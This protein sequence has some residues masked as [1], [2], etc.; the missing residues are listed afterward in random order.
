M[1]AAMSAA[2]FLILITTIGKHFV[3]SSRCD[4]DLSTESHSIMM[5]GDV[6]LGGIMQLLLERENYDDF[7]TA[8]L[9]YF[10]HIAA[11]VFAVEEINKHPDLLPNITLGFHIYDTCILE[12]QAIKSVLTILTGQ[13]KIIPNYSCNVKNTVAAFI[14]HHISSSTFATAVLTGIYRYPQITYGYI[15]PVFNNRIY[16][17]SLFQMVPNEQIQSK[18]IALLLQHFGW[19]WVGIVTSDN[20]SNLR[21]S[22]ELQDAIVRRGGCVEFIMTIKYLVT[23]GPDFRKAM[24]V[25][26]KS[27]CTVIILNTSA[28]ALLS[29]LLSMAKKLQTRKIVIL[30]P[31]QTTFP[32][33]NDNQYIHLFNGSLS[34][35]AHRGNIPGL[36]EFLLSGDISK[37]TDST[38]LKDVWLYAFLCSFPNNTYCDE[39]PIFSNLD[40]AVYDVDNFRMTHN[41][42]AAVHA[43]AHALHNM[44]AHS[45]H[46]DL[47]IKQLRQD[48]QPWVITDYLRKVNFLT[49]GGEEIYFSEEEKDFVKFDIINY[50]VLLNKT[51]KKNHVG[52]LISTSQQGLQISINDSTIQ[53]SSAFTQ[54]PHSVCSESCPPGFRKA[55]KKGRPKCCFDCVPCSE[56]EISNGTVLWIF[57]MYIKTPIVKANNQNLSYIL[58]VSLMLCFLCSLL[59]IGRPM[60]ITC[61]IRQAAF[62]IIFTIAVSSVL[63]KTMTV[64]IAFNA[65]KPNSKLRKWVGTR[66]PGCLILIC[67]LGEVLICIV[68][69]IYS[70]PFP[71]YDTHSEQDKMILQCNEGSATIFYVMVSYIGFLAFFCFVVAF[72][73]RKLPDTFNE[74]Q[75][76]TFS[77]LVF[78][79]VWVSFIPT[80]VSTKGKY[81]VAVEVFAILTSGAGLLCCIFIPKCH[82]I[83]IRPEFNT[84][85]CLS[86]KKATF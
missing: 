26:E 80:Y 34:V 37:Y 48:W 6:I 81:M 11:F 36:R 25:I 54:T 27:S 4:L 67:S 21:K 19:S 41:V 18:A 30:P 82:T 52:H 73:V 69:W 76:I 66:I 50:V 45:N 3:S 62:G 59:F 70:P 12:S 33:F 13:R 78:C 61:L 72:L 68:W 53:W 55:P 47:D 65:M 56:G 84:R 43:V 49:P 42:Y 64:V 38:I 58:L 14:G 60:K 63:A 24:D 85:E 35:M 9:H 75:Y 2:I 23:E 57:I 40:P 10:R 17:S 46:K 22:L 16:F 5:D 77:M 51:I 79:S 39:K 7:D 44:Y 15:D 83:L 8:S 29:I 31:A 20:E 32:V 1:H 71:D 86:K 74:A 28:T